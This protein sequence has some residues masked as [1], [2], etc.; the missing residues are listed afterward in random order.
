MQWRR[1]WRYTII[2]IIMTIIF[3]IAIFRQQF[4]LQLKNTNF[5]EHSSNKKYIEWEMRDA[6]L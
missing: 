1:P 3:L 6:G 2:I 5:H 4:F